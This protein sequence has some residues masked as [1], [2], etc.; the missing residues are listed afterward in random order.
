MSGGIIARLCEEDRAHYW[1][2]RFATRLQDEA[3]HAKRAF[4]SQEGLV[5]AFSMSVARVSNHPCGS[6]GLCSLSEQRSQLVELPI[7]RRDHV[8][9]QSRAVC[10]FKMRLSLDR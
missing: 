10:R 8:E 9:G 7:L 6:V 5:E 2:E 4:G 1:H 3:L